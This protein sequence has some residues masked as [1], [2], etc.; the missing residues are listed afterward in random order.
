MA[1]GLLVLRVVVGTTLLGARSAKAR[2]S[3]RRHRP[4]GHRRLASLHGLSHPERRWRSPSRLAECSGALLALG[5]LTP[6]AS[7][8][9]V[10]AMFVA[11]WVAHSMKGFWVGNGGYEYNLLIVAAAVTIAATG[12]GPFLDRPRAPLGRQPERP[13][14]GRRRARRSARKRARRPRPAAHHPAAEAER[15]GGVSARL[16]AG[17]HRPSSTARLLIGVRRFE[18]RTSP[19]RTER[20]TRLRHT[21]SDREG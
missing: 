2:R 5:F 7:F 17:T 14:V 21:P 8:G 11:I 13:L 6:L 12:P 1:Y 15:R 10:S 19:T 20:A 4:D 9:I 18:L 3:L 16:R